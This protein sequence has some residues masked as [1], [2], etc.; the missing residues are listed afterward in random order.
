MMGNSCKKKKRYR[1]KKHGSG[2][3]WSWLLIGF[4]AYILFMMLEFRPEFQPVRDTTLY[5]IIA[6]MIPSGILLYFA[7]IHKKHPPRPGQIIM[8]LMAFVFWQGLIIPSNRLILLHITVLVFAGTGYLLYLMIKKK[9]NNE[10]L[11]FSTGFFSIMMLQF[12]RDYTY[13]DGNSMHH[14]PVA[15]ILALIAGG[16]ACYLIFNG[17][18][19]LKD[20]RISEKVCWCIMALFASF[21]MFC[22]T[23]NNLNYM[24]DFSISEQ[25]QMEIKDKEVVS[26]NND[27]YYKFTLSYKGEEIVLNVMQTTYFQHDI[28][29]M[30]PVE[31]Y[32]GF[33]GDP[34]YIAE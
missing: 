23:M 25:Y 11:M 19:K 2:L 15:L 26:T 7:W 30:F 28:G 4:A 20:D 12:M 21:I 14:W 16:A 1:S 6:K 17:Y 31:L 33:F 5:K 10:A 13:V 27:T 24:L 32:R 8:T 18:I 22:A 3:H 34:Y 9:K 29:N